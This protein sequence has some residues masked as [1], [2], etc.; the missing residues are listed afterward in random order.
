LMRFAAA[1]VSRIIWGLSRAVAIML[2]AS[3]ES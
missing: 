1:S 2:R 3:F